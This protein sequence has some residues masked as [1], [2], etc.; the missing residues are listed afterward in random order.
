[1]NIP[2][3]NDSQRNQC[4][5]IQTLYEQLKNSTDEHYTLQEF[6]LA[7]VYNYIPTEEFVT[8]YG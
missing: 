2:K 5:Q 4:Q 3:L 1:M 7:G 8:N 6:L